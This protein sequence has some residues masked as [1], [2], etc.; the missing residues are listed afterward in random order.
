MADDNPFDIAIVGGGI[1]GVTLAAGLYHRGIKVKLFEQ[2]QGF[3][4]VGA[5]IG[6]TANTIRCMQEINP[7]V[8]EGLRAAGSAPNDAYTYLDAYYSDPNDAN[9]QKDLG[10]LNAG[11][12]GWETV[13]RDL[14]VMEMVKRLPQDIFQLNSR[15]AHV[16]QQGGNGKVVMKFEDGTVEEVD[17]R[18]LI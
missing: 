1:V 4:E 13:R 6:F 18:T 17:A 14:F 2:A 16:E 10:I 3:R 8:T 5:G 7:I 11:P 9:F 12:K 15:L